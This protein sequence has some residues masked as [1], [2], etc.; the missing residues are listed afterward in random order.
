MKTLFDVEASNEIQQRIHALSADSPR[1][2]GKMTSPQALAHCTEGLKM[3]T[4][5]IKFKRAPVG[6]LF[7]GSRSHSLDYCA[8][9]ADA[10]RYF[11]GA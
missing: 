9:R 4:G 6:Y 10:R 11:R 2:W 3:A 8:P 7:G 1:Q 5:E